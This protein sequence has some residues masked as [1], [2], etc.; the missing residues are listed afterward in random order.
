VTQPFSPIGV[1]FLDLGVVGG[2]LWVVLLF[3]QAARRLRPYKLSIRQAAIVYTLLANAL[4]FAPKWQLSGV[5]AVG[6]IAAALDA[7]RRSRPFAETA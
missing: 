6:L 7:R 3:L 4:F 1:A 2:T 5:L